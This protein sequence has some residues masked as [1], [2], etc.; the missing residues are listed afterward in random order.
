MRLDILTPLVAIWLPNKPIGQAVEIRIK[1]DLSMRN[2]P[3]ELH[4]FAIKP[5]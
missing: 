2:D 1:P 3:E 4:D 5:P